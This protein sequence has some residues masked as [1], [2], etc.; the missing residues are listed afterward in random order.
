MKVKTTILERS[1]NF[2]ACAISWIEFAK[3][4]LIWWNFLLSKMYLVEAKKNRCLSLGDDG[5]D[6]KGWISHDDCKKASSKSFCLINNLIPKS[7]FLMLVASHKSCFI[8][9]PPKA[10]FLHDGQEKSLIQ[11]IDYPSYFRLTRHFM[12]WLLFK[13][14]ISKQNSWNSY[15]GFQNVIVT[16]VKQANICWVGKTSEETTLMAT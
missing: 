4:T 13:M 14:P 12:P 8:Y 6:E 2:C 9:T 7:V 3:S 10:L 16:G 11:N 15:L 1:A 5:R